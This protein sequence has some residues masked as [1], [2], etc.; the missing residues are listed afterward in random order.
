[1]NAAEVQSLIETGLPGAQV[2]LLR[3][4]DE[5]IAGWVSRRFDVKQPATTIAWR[6][7]FCGALI[8]RTLIHC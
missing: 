2:R 6:A 3:G 1:M 5:P 8:L 4:S 7:R